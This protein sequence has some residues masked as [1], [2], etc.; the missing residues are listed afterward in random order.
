M[1]LQRS[2]QVGGDPF[3]VGQLLSALKAGR[4]LDRLDSLHDH[5]VL[6]LDALLRPLAVEAI[7]RDLTQRRVARLAALARRR[8][9]PLRHARELQDAQLAAKTLAAVAAAGLQLHS[10]L[11]D[12]GFGCGGGVLGRHCILWIFGTV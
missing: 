2:S 10:E 7:V 9:L 12:R 5:L 11:S 4:G 8:A 3:V 6:F 1:V